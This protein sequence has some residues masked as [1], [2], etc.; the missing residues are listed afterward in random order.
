MPIDKWQSN[1]ENSQYEFESYNFI[2]PTKSISFLLR[3]NVFKLEK[4]NQ[5]V[6]QRLQNLQKHVSRILKYMQ[7]L[8]KLKNL[9]KIQI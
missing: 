4:K 6:N 7:A 1:Q 2:I 8:R 5:E 3:L 9:E